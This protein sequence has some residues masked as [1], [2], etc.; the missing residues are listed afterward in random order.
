[1]KEEEKLFVVKDGR[2]LLRKWRGESVS[3]NQGTISRE[4]V[5]KG[6]VVKTSKGEE[7][8]V[9][10]PTL[11]DRIQKLGKGARPIYEYDA[12]L[13]IGLLSLTKK[14]VVLESGTGSGCMTLMISNVAKHVDSY[15]KVERHYE[16]AKENLAGVENV[17][18]VH[19]DLFEQKLTKKYDAI[20]L[21][22]QNPVEAIEKVHAQ[23][24]VGRFLAV[25][26]PI[27]D[28]VKP[29]VEK[30]NELEFVQVKAI[31]LDLKEITVKKYA[32]IEGLFGYP[33]F[34][35]VGRKFK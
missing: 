11:R 31:L 30:L 7:V 18:L 14:D 25:F 9:M 21:D 35:I 32:R 17:T 24:K 6:G 3:L 26:T 19:G 22:M 20:F 10:A 16:N 12:G 1:M 27:M 5:A 13:I 23:L 2:S 8:L 28:N 4:D 33:G 29:V 15:E 34:V